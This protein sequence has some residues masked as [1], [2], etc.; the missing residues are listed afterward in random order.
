MSQMKKQ[1]T[2]IRNLI[3]LSSFAALFS[4]S[5][6]AALGADSTDVEVQTDTATALT[7]GDE[8]VDSM[9]AT[10]ESAA[11]EVITETRNVISSEAAAA[12]EATVFSVTEYEAPHYMYTTATVN[13]RSGAG[14][15]YDSV[16]RM[17]WGSETA[18]TGETDNGWYEIAYDGTTAFIKGDYMASVLPGTPY[19]FVGD[20][21]TVQLQ[22]AVG[23]T[24]KAYIAKVGEGYT[25]FRDTALPSIS[26]YAGPGTKMIINFGVNDLSNAD[27]YIAL[28]NSNIDSWLAEGIT[29]Y[30]AAVTPV[31]D[32]PTVT[33]AEIEAFN[34]RLK[35]ELD[36]RINWLDG[37][38]Y[39]TQTGFSTGDGL[40]YNADTYRSLY[41]YYM[42]AISQL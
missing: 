19:V 20:S 39:L 8:I 37:Y 42:S 10:I 18:V 14:T 32:Y 7:S 21:R 27:K 13:V 6:L 26:D 22:M 1:N 30:Y 16:G 15:D 35:S 25:Y 28:V 23:S 24:D 4:L 40:H 2:K 5:S 41:S 33:N 29:V 3:I 9:A 34:A 31:S 12:N 36:S 38:T 11:T 17:K